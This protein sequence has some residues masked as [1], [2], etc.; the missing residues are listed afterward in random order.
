[1]GL[2]FFPLA[3]L[4]GRPTARIGGIA[5]EDPWAPLSLG[6]DQRSVE[7]AMA[8]LPARAHGLVMEE[9]WRAHRAQPLL[10]R[11]IRG[12]GAGATLREIWRASGKTR[13]GIGEKAGGKK[14]TV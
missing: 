4:P 11:N 8:Y 14:M 9:F 13:A 7:R 2:A 10:F 3:L 6:R 1:L 5:G 12:N